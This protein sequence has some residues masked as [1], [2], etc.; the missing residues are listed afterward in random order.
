MRILC[1]LLL[2]LTGTVACQNG[3]SG[4]ATVVQSEARV[5]NPEITRRIDEKREEASDQSFPRLSEIPTELPDKYEQTVI[6]KY[7]NQLLR[8]GQSLSEMISSAQSEADIIRTESIALWIDGRRQEMTLEEAANRLV[9]QLENDK[10]KAKALR[11]GGIPRLGGLP[12]KDQ[13]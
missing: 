9:Q 6:N 3:S 11:A 2:V 1:V 12:P 8:E 13:R 5:I 7:Q 4:S 10:A